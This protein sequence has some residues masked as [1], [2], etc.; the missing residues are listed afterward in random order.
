MGMR[1]PCKEQRVHGLLQAQLAS[2]A[3]SSSHMVTTPVSLPAQVSSVLSLPRCPSVQVMCAGGVRCPQDCVR[4]GS[5][6]GSASGHPAAA[7]P[8]P[9]A[10]PQDHIGGTM[11]NG[12]RLDVVVQ[13]MLHAHPVRC[14]LCQELLCD[15]EGDKFHIREGCGAPPASPMPPGDAC[16]PRYSREGDWRALTPFPPIPAPR[17]PLSPPAAPRRGAACAGPGAE[18]PSCPAGGD[19]GAAGRNSGFLRELGT[20]LP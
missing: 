13:E 1:S 20:F 8:F 4:A 17:V 11:S 18:E 19:V 7:A 2:R 16:I 14:W 3:A 10:L 12:E 5:R 6:R 15:S 9:P